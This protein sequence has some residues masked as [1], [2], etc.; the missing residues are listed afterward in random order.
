MA[1]IEPLCRWEFHLSPPKKNSGRAGWEQHSPAPHG[2]YL[3]E[4]AEDDAFQ[5]LVHVLQRATEGNLS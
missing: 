5:T 2:S 4:T 3:G 1:M